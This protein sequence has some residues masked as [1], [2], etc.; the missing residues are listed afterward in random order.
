MP[1]IG[2]NVYAKAELDLLPEDVTVQISQP[3]AGAT[4][5]GREGIT[6]N[7]EV[8]GDPQLRLLAGVDFT[9]RDGRVEESNRCSCLDNSEPN[10]AFTSRTSESN[11]CPIC[12]RVPQGLTE[13]QFQD[14]SSLI[15]QRTLRYGNDIRVQ[16]SRAACTARP[17]SDIDIAIRVSTEDFYRILNDPTLSKLSNP[18]PGSALERTRQRAI[19][20]GRIL[21]DFN[22][23]GG[24]SREVQ[25]ILC[26]KTQIAIVEIGKDFD[27]GPWINLR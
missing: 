18:N 12:P 2:L 4:L 7:S 23:L 26:I 11:S 15:R 19:A 27:Q 5:D 16:G 21:I 3:Q 14:I 20:Q 8:T 10:R 24:L 17:D 1:K 13:E 25:S 6:L 22:R 9:L